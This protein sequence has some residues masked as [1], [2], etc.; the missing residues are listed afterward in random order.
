MNSEFGQPK[1]A[2]YCKILVLDI[3]I[4]RIVRTSLPTSFKVYGAM[5]AYNPSVTDR[6]APVPAPFT[7]GSHWQ[8][9]ALSNKIVFCSVIFFRK[10]VSVVAACV[11]IASLV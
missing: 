3:G 11:I 4:Y 5:C 2:R 1:A 6:F 10:D 7:Q 8:C 9:T